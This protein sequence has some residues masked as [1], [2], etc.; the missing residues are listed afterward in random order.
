MEYVLDL[1]AEPHDPSRPV[2]CFD[3]T[4]TQLLADVR[5][6][7]PAQ[8]GRPRRQEYRDTVQHNASDRHARRL[9]SL[10][11]HDQTHDRQR[12]ANQYQDPVENGNPREHYCQ[13]PQDHTG[14][15]Q[16]SNRQ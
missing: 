6:P 9:A 2:V 1:Y 5:Q 16:T 7:L 3:E 10:L 14:D 8:P 12:Q 15:S 13:D 11:A 4:T